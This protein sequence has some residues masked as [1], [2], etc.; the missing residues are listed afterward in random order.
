[1]SAARPPSQP[2]RT[3]L[4]RSLPHPGQ[5]ER[6]LRRSPWRLA[7]TWAGARWLSLLGGVLA[8]SSATALAVLPQFRVEQI[9]MRRESK[10][11]AEAITRATQLSHVVGHNIFVVNSQRVAQEVASI[12]SV[13]SARVTPRLPNGMEIDIV[14]RTPIATW[15]TAAATFLVDDQGFLI[16]DTAEVPVAKDLFQVKDTTGRELQV[17]DRVNQRALLAARELSKALPEVGVR[18][19]EVEVGAAGL[20]FTSETN[21]RIIV[22][23]PDSLNIKLANLASVVELARKNSLKISLLDLRPQDRPYYQLAQ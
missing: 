5:I 15:H 12:P 18:V 20:V 6:A 22:G 11:S 16:A 19:R 17:G 8:L 3:R 21:W 1:M 7:L 14:E 4:R 2:Q 13:L 10:S 9:T 23:E